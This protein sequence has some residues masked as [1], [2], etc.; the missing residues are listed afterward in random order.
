ME[1]LKTTKRNS[2]DKE[3]EKAKNK[4]TKNAK[5]ENQYFLGRLHIPGED[6]GLLQFEKKN[7]LYGLFFTQMKLF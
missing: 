2:I 6:R 5:F 4:T 7:H 1:Q 3:K